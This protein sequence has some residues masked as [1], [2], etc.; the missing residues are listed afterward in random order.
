MSRRLAG[1]FLLISLI[2]ASIAHAKGAF[3]VVLA[4]NLQTGAA[5]D[6]SDNATLEQF[7]VFDW[8]QG[9]VEAPTVTSPGIELRRGALDDGDFRGFDVLIYYPEA[10]DY[11]FYAGLTNAQGE[12]CVGC[13]E[14]DGKWYRLMPEAKTEFAALFIEAASPSIDWL[15]SIGAIMWSVLA[16]AAG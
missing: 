3:E 9:A 8:Q 2:S 16:I 10:P 15:Q 12:L 4:T 1:V 7:F 6:V 13:S 5:Q 11:I 14:Y